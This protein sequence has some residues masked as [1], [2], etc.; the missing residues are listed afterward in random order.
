MN[1]WYK[2][3]T[4]LGVYLAVPGCFMSAPEIT[5]ASPPACFRNDISMYTQ[6]DAVVEAMVTKSRRWSEGA[7]TLHLVAK[8]KVLDVFKGDVTRDDILIVT[9]TCLDKPIPERQLGYPATRNYCRGLTGLRLPGVNSKDG[10]PAMKS[11]SKPNWILFLKKDIRKG[12]PQLTW[13]EA[14]R[15]SFSGPCRQ[16]RDD[17]PLEQRD[18]FDRLA[19]RVKSIGH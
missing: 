11:G 12:A 15:T 19:Q 17:I 6:S 5:N 10:K 2:A 8:Y 16:T 4:R 13:V 18:A 9:D 1:R 7:A 3:I 14:S